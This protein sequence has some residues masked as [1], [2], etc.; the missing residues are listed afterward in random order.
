MCEKEPPA[1]P[2]LGEARP[3][4]GVCVACP[5][6][7]AVAGRM[8]PEDLVPRWHLRAPLPPTASQAPAGSHRLREAG[9]DGLTRFLRKEAPGSLFQQQ[10]QPKH[11]SLA[12][13]S[14][15]PSGIEKAS[16]G[17]PIESSRVRGRLQSRLPA[18]KQP[19]RW[20]GRACG[21]SH[22]ST[23]YKDGGGLQENQD[24]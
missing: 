17:G 8:A 3:A 13:P 19:F 22:A 15:T 1:W 16:S 6:A 9:L 20:D 23:V 2:K 11:C 14:K 5:E 12:V 7:E 10:Q 21:V 24:R 4:S 18:G